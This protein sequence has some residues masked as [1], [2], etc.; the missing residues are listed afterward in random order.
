MDAATSPTVGT[1]AGPDVDVDE[2]P[3]IGVPSI[4]AAADPERPP[5]AVPS[6]PVAGSSDPS[7]PAPTTPLPVDGT[8]TAHG[9]DELTRFPP[10]VA[11]RLG[12]YVYLLVDPRSGRAF[13]VGRGRGDR[14]FRHL[15]AARAGAGRHGGKADGRVRTFAMLDRI[16]DVESAGRPVR[17]DILRYGLSRDEASLV[18]AATNEALG[19]A[20][21]T[22][23][24]GQRHPVAES[25]SRL[26]KRAKFKRGHQVVLLRVGGTGADTAYEQARHGWR[27]GK[28]WIDL[29]SPRSPVWAVLVAA[30]LVAAV[31][32]I[33]RWEPTPAVGLR[34]TGTAVPVDR[35]SFVGA[36]D[37]E[38]ERRYR[39]RS[40]SA[41][42]GSGA[43]SRVTYVRSGPHW[44]NSA[45]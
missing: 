22:E 27:I 34:P 8:D 30:D 44:V 38:L 6:V 35:F 19:L 43:P 25:G 41:Y 9:I 32:R 40:V 24:A 37:P 12:S 42:L 29:D 1:T 21:E 16:R 20:L 10:G 15:E 33:E 14:C 28:R 45:R 17:I 4:P 23:L 39:G 18:E 2:P 26:A 36:P 7:A 11:D 31:Y 13:C 3:S 5:V